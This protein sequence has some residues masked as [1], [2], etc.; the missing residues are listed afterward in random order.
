MCDCIIYFI[1]VCILLNYTDVV[2]VHIQW[3]AMEAGSVQVEP[4]VGRMLIAQF[5]WDTTLIAGCHDVQRQSMAF[6]ELARV[7]RDGVLCST[8][9]NCQLTGTCVNMHK[10]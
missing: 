4:K 2:H 9:T 8:L 1:K 7:W 6:L 5:S 3:L 10:T